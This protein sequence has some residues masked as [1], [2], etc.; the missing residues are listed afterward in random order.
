MVPVVI[1]Q[2]AHVR[3]S[4][5]NDAPLGCQFAHAFDPDCPEDVPHQAM[6]FT[7][8]AQALGHYKAPFVVYAP[9]RPEDDVE[10]AHIQVELAD[11]QSIVESGTGV[12]VEIR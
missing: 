10:W 5:A 6:N 2:G 8:Y 9:E 4:E 7:M 3:Y 12:K 1:T 11:F